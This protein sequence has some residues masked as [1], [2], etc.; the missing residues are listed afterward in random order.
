MRGPPA[1]VLGVVVVALVRSSGAGVAAPRFPAVPAGRV[2]RLRG[3]APPDDEAGVTHMLLEPSFLAS[4]GSAPGADVR[5]LKKRTRHGPDSDADDQAVARDKGDEYAQAFGDL[6]LPERYCRMRCW[7]PISARG[8]CM[9]R[10]AACA[11][12]AC[13]APEASTLS[14]AL[15]LS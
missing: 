4:R 12:T 13:C 11:R 9:F 10:H 8:D 14:L 7:R 15:A 1:L 5:R 3:G 2:L 6:I